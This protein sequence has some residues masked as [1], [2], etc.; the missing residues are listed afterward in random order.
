MLVSVVQVLYTTFVSSGG[1]WVS[2]RMVLAQAGIVAA[3][4]S[5]LASFGL[6]SLCG[7]KF[8][9]LCGVMPFMVLGK[10]N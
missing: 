8:V 9:D 2:S 7:L 3:L 6:V 1:N 5:I 4:L 10:W